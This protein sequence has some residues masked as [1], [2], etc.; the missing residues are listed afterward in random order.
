MDP[1]NSH[2]LDVY[3]ANAPE[4]RREWR[5]SRH[6]PVEVSGFDAHGRFFTERTSTLDVS[7]SGCCFLLNAEIE[8]DSVVSVRVIR[9]RDGLLFADPPVRFRVLSA[10]QS[11]P[12]WPKWT[13]AGARLQSVA[14]DGRISSGPK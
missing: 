2:R 6:V 1:Q 13:V 9:R 3:A 7:D 10:R 12:G 11:Y 5:E 14:L 4:R 8:K